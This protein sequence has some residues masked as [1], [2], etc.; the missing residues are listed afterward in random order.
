MLLT[1]CSSMRGLPLAKFCKDEGHKK[2]VSNKKV[3]HVQMKKKME[4]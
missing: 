1:I 3:K 2:F 4:T